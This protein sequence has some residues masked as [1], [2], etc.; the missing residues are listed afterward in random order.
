MWERR[1]GRS[2]TEGAEFLARKLPETEPEHSVHED[3]FLEVS[4]LRARTTSS[5]WLLV[6]C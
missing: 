5:R 1:S 4:M 3:F 2:S 6:F